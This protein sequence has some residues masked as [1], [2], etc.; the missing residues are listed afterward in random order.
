[1]VKLIK[2]ILFYDFFYEFLI[3]VLISIISLCADIT[4]FIISS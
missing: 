4:E 1:M 3:K 2:I